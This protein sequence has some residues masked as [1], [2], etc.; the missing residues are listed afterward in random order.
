MSSV[1]AGII[2]AKQISTALLHEFSLPTAKDISMALHL[3]S[4]SEIFVVNK[5]TK[6]WSSVDPAIAFFGNGTWKVLKDAQQLPENSVELAFKSHRD[7]VLLNGSAQ[8]LGVVLA[9][10]R[11]KKPDAKICYHKINEA[12]KL[13]E[14]SLTVTHRVIFQSKLEQSLRCLR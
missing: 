5:G 13:S 7:L 1:N 10:M 2:E 4:E 14:F 6:E 9:E 12:E 8:S 3:R 11:A